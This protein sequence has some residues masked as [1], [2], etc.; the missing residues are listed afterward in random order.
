MTSANEKYPS[1]Q[2]GSAEL[3]WTVTRGGALSNSDHLRTLG[4]ERRDGQKD[5]EVVNET[6][7]EG[8]VRDLKVTDRRLIIR[9]KNTGAW[10]RVRSTTVSDTVFYDMEFWY[11]LC[12]RY[13]VSP[14]NPQSHC[15]R[16]GTAFG[17]THI[18]SY[19]TG[20]L[21]IA[22][23]NKISDEILY[24]PQRAFTPASLHTNPLIHQSRTISE[25][26]ICQ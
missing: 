6:K 8:L 2:R 11:V 3:I 14:L 13:N 23:H 16:C 22:R 17:V 12:T 21:G 7:I 4:E 15:D 26:E 25:Q 5:R 24:L 1:S 9:A 10:M 20:G 19:S 18:L